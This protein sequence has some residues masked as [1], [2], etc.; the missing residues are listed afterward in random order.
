MRGVVLRR[1]RRRR[2]WTAGLKEDDAIPQISYPE[3][4]SRATHA[5]LQEY[6]E[7]V[8]SRWWRKRETSVEQ[9]P[10]FEAVR[11][12]IVDVQAYAR[13]HGGDIRLLGVSEE[14]NVKIR[15]QG[16]CRGCPMSA[17]T[18]RHGVEERLR[19]LVPEAARVTVVD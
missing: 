12:A 5:C 4:P 10:L 19:Q 18:I 3:K 14:G 9:G 17:F 11:S 1:P 16:T 15:L 6:P 8:L 7:G 2:I 13:S